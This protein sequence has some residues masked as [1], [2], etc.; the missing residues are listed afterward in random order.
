MV[1]EHGVEVQTPQ[2]LVVHVD[3]SNDEKQT[4]YCIIDAV[5]EAILG[6]DMPSMM[7]CRSSSE[8]FFHIDDNQDQML[9]L[10]V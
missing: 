10:N 4:L 8:S 7:V 1:G 6:D 5:I 2:D 3:T 9:S